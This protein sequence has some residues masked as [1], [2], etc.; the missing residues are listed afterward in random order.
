LARRPSNSL[1]D[2]LPGA[3]VELAFDDRDDDLAAHDLPLVVSVAVRSS[4][5]QG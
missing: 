2:L 1:E 3:A 4:L 5:I